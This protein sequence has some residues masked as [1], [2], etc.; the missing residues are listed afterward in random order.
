MNETDAR[1]LLK[2]SREA[3]WTFPSSSGKPVLGDEPWLEPLA[4]EQRHLAEAARALDEDEAI[5]LAA[6]VWRLWMFSRDV[7]GGHAFLGDVLRRRAGRAPHRSRALY[8]DGLFAFWQGA[9]DDSHARNEEA[10]AS[11]ADDAEALALGNLGLSRAALASGDAETARAFAVQA[12]EHARAGSDALGQAPLHLHA[13]SVRT[14]GD[15]DGAAK[16]FRESLELNRR[17]GDPGMIGVELHNLGHVELHRGDVDEAER[18]FAELAERGAADDP[19]SLALAQLNDAAVALARGDRGRAEEL[20]ARIDAGL[21]QSGTELAP[22]DRFE[23]ESLRR[24][25]TA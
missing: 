10:L 9:I 6:N 1:R 18:L 19:Y 2:L 4:A 11:A 13:Q 8:G 14:L 17:I 5:E 20:L 3:R 23:V 15:Y 24:R 22:D 7:D 25:L 16:L 12:R 21:D